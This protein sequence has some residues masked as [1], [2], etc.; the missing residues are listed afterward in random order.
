MKPFE[1]AFTAFKC[2]L[3]NSYSTDFVDLIYLPCRRKVIWQ[4]EIFKFVATLK[5]GE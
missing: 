4:S 5:T 2:K 3:F 1:S